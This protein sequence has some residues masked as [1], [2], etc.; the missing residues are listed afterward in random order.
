MIRLIYDHKGLLAAGWLAFLLTCPCLPQ[1]SAKRNADPSNTGQTKGT[2]T[3][4]GTIADTTGAMLPEARVRVFPPTGDPRNAPL[5]E[6]QTDREG[7]FSFRLPAGTYVLQVQAPDF[8]PYTSR[9]LALRAGGDL[10]VPIRLAVAGLAE[11]VTADSGERDAQAGGS[12]LLFEGKSLDL[13]SDDDDTLLRQLRV[14][15]GGGLNG[16][17]QIIVNGFSGGQLP[18]KSSIRSIRI[19]GNE[20]SAYYDSPGFGRIEVQT[21]PGASKLHGA[22]N[23]SGTDQP[24]NASNPYTGVQPP[25]YQFLTDGNLNGPLGKNTSY[26]LSEQVQDFANNATVN[27]VDPTNTGNLISEALPAPQLTQTYALRLDRQFS[28]NHYGFLRDQW[29]Q[30]HITNSGITPLV[31]P[32]AAFASNTLTN[33]LQAADTLILGPH[34]INETRFQ[35][36]RSRL[37]QDPNSTAPTLIAEG[38]F[39]AGGST[40][41]ALRDNGDHYELQD[42]LELERGH[43]ALRTGLRL[44][45][46]REANTS[47]GN[48]NGQFIFPSL[49]AYNTTLQGLAAGMSPAQ[50]RAAGGGASQFNQTVG[51]SAALLYTDDFAVFAE[52]DW[53]LRPD[54]TASYGL[55]F[56]SQSAIPNHFNPMPRLS[57]NWSPHRG[58]S[59]TPVVSV[60]AGY[61]IF[62]D[63]FAA[64]NLLQAVRQNGVTETGYFLQNPDDYP[65]LPS[66]AALAGGEATI[67]R[68]NPALH[69]SYQQLGGVLVERDLGK[70]GSLQGRYLYSHRTHGY[71]SRNINAPLPGTYDPANPAGGTRPF[72]PNRNIYQYSSDSNGNSSILS[73]SANVQ[74]GK[75]FFYAAFDGERTYNE[76]TY[77]STTGATSFPANQYNLAADYGR[78]SDSNKYRLAAGAVWTLPRGF[79]L[80]PYLDAHTGN[81]FDITTGTDGNGDTIFNDRPA[82]ATDLSRAS[83]VRTALG[84]FDTNPQP[85]QTIIPRN[86]GTDPSYVWVDLTTRYV[87]RVGPRPAGKAGE[88]AKTNRPYTLRFQ[89]E[90]QNLFNHNNPG[91][92]VGVLSSPLFGRSLSLASDFSTFTASNRTILLQS[93]FSF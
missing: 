10:R 79:S 41:Q 25:Y 32:S 21:K 43:H 12:T 29:S 27:A 93:V 80:R 7:N 38:S 18:P 51:Q 87:I 16:G 76:A 22:L 1:R 67:Y 70:Y 85:G 39:I 90:T 75:V 6:A 30:T 78:S 82:F 77:D 48:F 73:A 52:D 46:Q 71:L 89:V 45:A 63:R 9:A 17:A 57:L 68:V 61:G 86:Y 84:N 40:T 23:V 42:Q 50:I 91:P 33:V 56:E 20:Y 47:T 92:P 88:T 13:L 5:A 81:P 65:M 37:R 49:T 69:A 35:Y 53:K 14:L 31:L 55:R 64:N 72:G 8:V 60:G 4:S 28:T 2:L 11:E 44:R 58:K 66:P 15:A 62:Y 83:V 26:F 54:L 24:L 19:N 74:L 3:L 59:S 36:L 34:T